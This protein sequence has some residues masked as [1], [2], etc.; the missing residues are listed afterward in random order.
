MSTS[1]R[2]IIRDG[3]VQA[4]TTLKQTQAARLPNF[5]ISLTYDQVEDCKTFPTYCVV[6]TDEQV[7]AH[8]LT[9]MDC[10]STLLTVLY[11]QDQKDPR[12]KLDAAIEDVYEAVM[13]WGQSNLASVWRMVCS[14]VTTDEGTRI[15]KPNAQAVL[16]WQLHYRR[17]CS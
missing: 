14:E 6:V 15:A 5:T 1:V 9:H 17:R 3:V 11:V 7:E 4:L 13:R 12:A 2:T 16:R 8:S 10:V